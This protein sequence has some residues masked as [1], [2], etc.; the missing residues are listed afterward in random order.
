MSI[1]E[2]QQTAEHKMQQSLEAFKSNLTK[3]RTGVRTLRCWTRCM[4]TT[5][6]PCCRCRRWP[7]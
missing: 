5:T 6:A 4:W 3:V 2:I 1:A 7:I